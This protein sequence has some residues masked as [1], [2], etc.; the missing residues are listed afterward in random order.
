MRTPIRLG[1]LAGFMI[2]VSL[3]TAAVALREQTDTP[4]EAGGQGADAAPATGTTALV[5]VDAGA[6]RGQLNNP[7]SYHNQAG[8]TT[9]LGPGDLQLVR[10]LRPTLTRVWSAPAAYH[11][12]NTDR[13]DYDPAG[14]GSGSMYGYLDQVS[15]YSGVLMMNVDQCRRELMT[16]ATPQRC[17]EV[18]RNGI[19]HY[20]Q[21][22]PGLRYVEIFNEP[23]R[24]WKTRPDEPRAMSAAE[25]YDWYRI[26]YQIVNEVNA[27]LRPAQ[28]LRVGGPVTH[29][30]NESYIEEFL[31][32]YRDDADPA[33]RLDFISYHQYQRRDDVAAV[34]AEKS[35]VQRWLRERGLDDRIP[36]FVTEY[37]VF[38]GGNGASSF[39]ED[40]LTHAAAMATLGYFYLE[41]GTDMPMHWVFN[42]SSND[43]K[44]MFVDG[45]DGAVYPYYN[46]VRMQRM[47]K[48]VR[49]PAGSDAITPAGLGV[50]ALA[51]RDASGIAVL[52]TNYQ[53][54]NRVTHGVT[55]NVGNLPAEFAGRRIRVERYLVDAV[56]SNYTHDPATSSLQRVQR[57]TLD[58]AGT[59]SATF[60]LTPNAMSLLVLTPVD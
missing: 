38:P 57:Y 14:Q 31:D 46:L 25:Y 52:A 11:D 59:V 39:T 6:S 23:D 40:L 9:L 18:L 32:R 34:A 12:P 50:N 29:T 24:P 55:V 7:A 33:K 26:G 2:V 35:T 51:T 27:E 3:L 49:V 10:D 20:K 53:W 58:P 30:F 56:T 1:L 37:G 16:R 48:K 60:D 54:T 17:R 42:H 43:R 15:G 13:Y 8:P 19:R 22:Y 36:T 41:G 4:D 21:R 28:P 45:A 44:S 5:T 47:L